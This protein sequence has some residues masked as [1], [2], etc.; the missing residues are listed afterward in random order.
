M[1]KAIVVFLDYLI[2]DVFILFNIAFTAL[3]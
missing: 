1:D 3:N 2:L